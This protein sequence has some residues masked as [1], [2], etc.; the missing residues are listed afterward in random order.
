MTFA[1]H[2]PADWTHVSIKDFAVGHAKFSFDYERRPDRISLN[3]STNNAAGYKIMFA[4]A[5]GIG[6]EFTSVTVDGNRK[7]IKTQ[8][9]AQVAQAR[10]EIPVRD[11][12][13]QLD[14]EFVSTVEIIPVF[15]KTKVGEHNK[16]LKIISVEKEARQLMI[17]VEGLASKTYALQITNAEKIT[18]VEGA[19][20]EDDKLKI[21]M[22]DGKSRQFVSHRIILHLQ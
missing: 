12:T 8:E 19:V 18:K 2:F 9:K 15:P 13:T 4:P 20:L 17:K 5:M 1:P 22:P 21:D 14:L 11:G 7:E 10:V 3:V 6:T 16:G